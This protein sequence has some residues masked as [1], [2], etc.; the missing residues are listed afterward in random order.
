[1][2]GDGIRGS[3]DLTPKPIEAEL[4]ASAVVAAIGKI[5]GEFK[6][7]GD[8]MES[9]ARGNDLNRYWKTQE[10]SIEGVLSSLEKF[11]NLTNQTNAGSLIKSFNSFVAQGGSVQEVVDRFGAGIDS[12]MD[13]ARSMAPVVAEAFSVNTLKNAFEGFEQLTQSGID[14]SNAFAKLNTADQSELQHA[15]EETARRLTQAVTRT[16]ELEEQ[17]K[18]VGNV[19]HIEELEGK[20]AYLSERGMTEFLHFLQANNIDGAGFSKWGEFSYFYDQIS[21]GALTS[22]DAIV[23]FKNQYGALLEEWSRPAFDVTQFE[24][25]NNMLDQLTASVQELKDKLGPGGVRQSVEDMNGALSESAG[26]AEKQSS[27]VSEA[28]RSNVGVRE[29][30]QALKEAAE[31]FREMGDSGN[32]AY[33]PITEV[34]NALTGFSGTDAENLRA[35]FGI[36]RSLGTLDNLSVGAASIRNLVNGLE[37]ISKITNFGALSVL[38]T[39]DFRNF[40]ELSIRKASLAN[41]AEYLPQIAT[42]NVSALK[43]LSTVDLRN[44]NDVKVDR[45]SARNLAEMLQASG[46]IREAG[47]NATQ[48]VVGA[49]AGNATQAVANLRQAIDELTVK[50]GS[51]FASIQEGIKSAFDFTS[52]NSNI[53]QTGAEL[54]KLSETLGTVEERYRRIASVRADSENELLVAKQA[55]ML[56][57]ISATTG[58]QYD[59]TMKD[60]SGV[61]AL[62]DEMKSVRE[63]YTRWSSEMA[64]EIARLKTEQVA[65]SQE[66]IEALKKRGEAIRENI[67]LI[68][69]LRTAEKGASTEAKAQTQERTSARNNEQKQLEALYTSLEKQAQKQVDAVTGKNFPAEEVANLREKYRALQDEIQR[70]RDAH[71]NMSSDAVASLREQVRAIEDQV[72]AMKESQ[73]AAKAESKELEALFNS[74]EKSAGKQMNSA[75]GKL[76]NTG[77]ADALMQKYRELQSEI[78]AVRASGDGMN[79]EAV[80]KLLEHAR[81]FEQLVNAV[82]AATAAERERERENQHSMA[83]Q[84]QILTLQQQI[85]AY[86]QKNPRGFQKYSAEFNAITEALKNGAS[87]SNSSS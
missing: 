68:E 79:S 65:A 35:T 86:I 53:Q 54:S 22:A 26:N 42:V 3:I 56:K 39:V 87:L 32:N 16:K 78:N 2:A 4:N 60:G 7:L 51:A 75:M 8:A 52:A 63:E 67:A 19:E 58:R 27:A 73:A 9:M 72:A 15:L 36:L 46:A 1:M 14:L 85:D 37:S 43:E 10:S 84:K 45:A 82:R 55:A 13:R 25:F 17:L 80:Q 70:C 21:K 62:A 81:A 30:A 31:G 12:I 18:R 33:G 83:T 76:G 64:A 6:K 11:Q 57:D 34:L 71:V 5:R 61:S 74:I 44:F 66:A 41:L 38:P 40:N 50:S 29:L 24:K 77:E 47:A 28:A 69:Q 23:E 48:G 20:L 59:R 49:E